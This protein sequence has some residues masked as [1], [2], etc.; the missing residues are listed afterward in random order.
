MAVTD[1]EDVDGANTVTSSRV[2]VLKRQRPDDREFEDSL[3]YN[4]ET[5]SQN[6]ECASD[7]LISENTGVL[8]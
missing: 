2:L 1:Q 4:S 3:G 5:V 6:K 8:S 7:A